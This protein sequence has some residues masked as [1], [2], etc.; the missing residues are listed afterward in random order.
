MAQLIMIAL[1][2]VASLIFIVLYFSNSAKYKDYIN[3]IDDKVFM[4]PDIFVVGMAVVQMFKINT[5]KKDAKKRQK[6]A[7]LFGEQYVSF[8]SMVL[9]AS[10]ISYL[11]MFFPIAFFLGAM[12]NQPIVAVLV[13]VVSLLFP[14]YVGMNIDTKITEQRN[15]ILLDYPGILSKM[16]LLIN[17]GMM[18]REAWELVGES[19]HTKLYREM[20][21]V[22]KKIKNGITETQ[23][24][25]EL[26][27]ACKINEMKKFVSIICQNLERGSSELVFVMRE[28][29][30]EAWNAKKN[31]AKM[32]GDSATAKLILPIGLTFVGILIMILVPIMANM[33]LS[34]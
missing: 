7:E 21:A 5:E 15:E 16:A 28:L 8:Y 19:G 2:A 1:G 34:M 20:Q 3:G 29:S 32:K 22:T 14:V 9:T 12:S 25:R 6:F 18:L 13:I 24:Y 4:M 27:D 30:D 33:N 23:A 26:A 11:M 10:T 31:V 17:A